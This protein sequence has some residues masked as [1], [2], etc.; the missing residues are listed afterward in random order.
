MLRMP[1]PSRPP[2]RTGRAPARLC[3]ALVLLASAAASADIEDL[4]NLERR[5]SRE[6]ATLILRAEGGGNFSVVGNAGGTLSYFNAWSESE[7]ELSA[8]ALL[9]GD[10]PQPQGGLTL[11]KLFG[12]GRGDFFLG[13]LALLWTKDPRGI[14]PLSPG[15]GSH[16]WL[17]LGAGF[18][19]RSGIWSISASGGITGNGV[20]Q[21]PFFYFRGG[22]GLGF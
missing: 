18:E 1:V 22:I 2:P 6:P 13:E 19:H 7:V 14:D 8:G 15:S 5:T 4:T 16:L 3:A 12:E 11:R 20:S 10:K 9:T 21:A 17:A